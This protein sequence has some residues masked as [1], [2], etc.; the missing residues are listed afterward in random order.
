MSKRHRQS[1]SIRARGVGRNVSARG[2]GVPMFLTINAAVED[3]Y[4]ETERRADFAGLPDAATPRK[5]EPRAAF[6]QKLRH[7]TLTQ[8]MID[9][10][11]VV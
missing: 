9:R 10:K 7:L 8:E 11:S 1:R 3:C 4:S 6:K 5:A 2:Q